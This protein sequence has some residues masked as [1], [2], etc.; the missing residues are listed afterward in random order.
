MEPVSIATTS[1][2][3]GTALANT[4][5]TVANFLAGQTGALKYTPGQSL[6]TLTPERSKEIQRLQGGTL[7]ATCS[8]Y[9]LPFVLARR[10]S[11]QANVVAVTV[12][13]VGPALRIG[14]KVAEKLADDRAVGG[15]GRRLA[16]K[17]VLDILTEPEWRDVVDKFAGLKAKFLIPLQI[18]CEVISFPY[19]TGGQ[20]VTEHHIRAARITRNAAE[21]YKNMFHEPAELAFTGTGFPVDGPAASYARL[22]WSMTNAG[23]KL[24]SNAK[25]RAGAIRLNLDAQGRPTPVLVGQSLKYI[26]LGAL[27]GPESVPLG[28]DVQPAAAPLSSRPD[29]VR[30]RTDLGNLQWG[31]NVDPRGVREALRRHVKLRHGV[32]L[33]DAEAQADLDNVFGEF[34][35]T[36][37]L[38]FLA[39]ASGLTEATAGTQHWAAM[40]AAAGSDGSDADRAEIVKR[41][42]DPLDAAFADYRKRRMTNPTRGKN[43]GDRT[44]AA[45]GVLT[46][47]LQQ[48]DRLLSA[49]DAALVALLAGG[50]FDD[51]AT[52][53]LRA[54]RKRILST[55]RAG[56]VEYTLARTGARSRSDAEEIVERTP[57]P[58]PGT[59]TFVE[60]LVTAV[61]A[62][63]PPALAPHLAS[64]GN[65]LGA[66]ND[67]VTNARVFGQA[68]PQLT[69]DKMTITNQQLKDGEA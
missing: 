27:T 34:K 7:R 20:A 43:D 40:W 63:V 48:V 50:V 69:R 35:K 26:T 56:C 55:V 3:A 36:E 18:E 10:S 13:V 6:T 29:A 65:R 68:L 62:A 28:G 5:C 41:M 30:Q 21:P 52:N 37:W 23:R 61:H 54:Q 57:L 53:G 49:Y 4:A 14:Q 15:S 16:E 25:D 24:R 67:R 64:L 31:A 42:Q 66:I 17:P 19:R 44:E 2:V 51:P 33:S 9:F 38:L 59:T 47:Y 45:N 32:R 39:V 58:A 8:R 1:A 46:T 12:P 22:D 11:L 60:A